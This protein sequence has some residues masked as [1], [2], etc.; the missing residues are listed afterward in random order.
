ME[1]IFEGATFWHDGEVHVGANA[2]AASCV[3]LHRR[4]ALWAGGGHGSRRRKPGQIPI[5]RHGLDGEGGWLPQRKFGNFNQIGGGSVGIGKPMV[6]TDVLVDRGGTS[7]A[8]TRERLVGEWSGSGRAGRGWRQPPQDLLALIHASCGPVPSRSRSS[9]LSPKDRGHAPDEG[10][11]DGS[12][13][14]T[15]SLG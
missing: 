2:D 12:P 6:I 15:T 1:K 10:R 9:R 13:N 3:R 4:G 5:V 11:A 7:A 14:T 8:R